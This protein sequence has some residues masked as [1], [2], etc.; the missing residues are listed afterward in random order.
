MDWNCAVMKQ[1]FVSDKVEIKGY[2]FENCD[3]RIVLR[4]VPNTNNIVIPSCVSGV[5]N[6]W[7]RKC[8]KVR[9]LKVSGGKGLKSCSGM[10]GNLQNLISLDLTEFDCSNSTDM[11]LMFYKCE[12]LKRIKF[13]DIDTSNVIYFTETFKY[14]SSL[15]ELDISMFDMSSAKV[16]KYMFASCFRLRKIKLCDMSTDTLQNMIGAFE[17]CVSL[18]EVNTEVIRGTNVTMCGYMFY[19]CLE[20]ES[21]DLRNFN[22]LALDEFIG[23]FLNCSHLKSVRLDSLEVGNA[24]LKGVFSGCDELKDVVTNNDRLKTEFLDSRKEL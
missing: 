19:G 18:K 6:N 14:C 5:E 22:P 24:K 16:I 13:G 7:L 8:D 10:F 12:K 23:V 17:Y 2:K 11:T 3:G 15:E 21:I 9:H 4:E 20:I 1:L